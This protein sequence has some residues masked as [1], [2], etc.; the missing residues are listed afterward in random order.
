[1]KSKVMQILRSIFNP[2]GPL[3]D[4]ALAATRRAAE[5]SKQVE[6]ALKQYE[7][8]RD[9]FAAL[10]HGIRNAKQRRIAR[11]EDK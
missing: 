7:S 1:M 2:T 6:E 4:E 11:E 5:S 10:A 8:A 3:R 9:P